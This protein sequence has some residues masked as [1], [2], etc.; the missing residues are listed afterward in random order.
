M[1]ARIVEWAGRYPILSIEDPAGQ[2]DWTAMAAVTAAIGDQVQIIGDD[3]L[4]TDG[5]TV[6]ARAPTP[7]CACRR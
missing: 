3:V 1:A 4:V 2:D 6:G 5:G 7:A